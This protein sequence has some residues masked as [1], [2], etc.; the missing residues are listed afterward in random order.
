MTMKEF[1]KELSTNATLSADAKEIVSRTV[2]RMEEES[3]A[4]NA[5][6]AELRGAAINIL[7]NMT[8]PVAASAVADELGISIPKATN[9]LKG[10]D[11]IKVSE[12]RVGNRIVK[13]YSF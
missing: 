2:S 1:W 12:V 3:A 10:L 13:G 9:I 4:K 8:D 5:E 7:T 6:N 11:G